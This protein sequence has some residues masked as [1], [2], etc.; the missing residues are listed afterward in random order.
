VAF[1]N[2]IATD[3]SLF[4]HEE[5]IFQYFLFLRELLQVTV[6]HGQNSLRQVRIY[7]LQDRLKQFLIERFHSFSLTLT[8]QLLKRGNAM[9]S[10]AVFVSVNPVSG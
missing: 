5:Q 3:Q 6:V 1:G 10:G 2:Q 9:Y 7:L 8:L 4:L